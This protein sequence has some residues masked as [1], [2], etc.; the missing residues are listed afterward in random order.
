MGAF[1]AALVMVVFTA[2]AFSHG[3]SNVVLNYDLGNQT[4]SVTVTHSPFSDSHY[5]KEIEVAKNGQSVGK[6]QY[7]SQPGDTFTYTYKIPAQP[8]DVLEAK[9]TCVKYGSKAGRMTVER[10]Q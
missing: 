1:A 4:L 7:N 2:P 9:A 5:V 8:G 6:Y 3:P 10:L